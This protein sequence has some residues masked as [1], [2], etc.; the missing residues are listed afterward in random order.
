MPP[1]RLPAAAQRLLPAVTRRFMPGSRPAA[2]MNPLV[3]VD[4]GAASADRLLRDLHDLWESHRPGSAVWLPGPAWDRSL[5]AAEQA[6]LP[7][8]LEKRL[9][10]LSFLAIPA[11]DQLAC[12]SAARAVGRILEAALRAGV[13]CGISV[14]TLAPRQPVSPT[15]RTTVQARTTL[16]RRLASLLSGGLV[17]PLSPPH[18]AGTAVL[19]AAV[20]GPPRQ[21]PS[22]RR[23]ISATAR[24]FGLRPADLVGQSRRQGVTAARAIAMFLV[25]T[26]T[27]RSLHAIGDSF[28]GRD[29]TTVLHSVRLVGRRI[30]SDPA[31]AQDIERLL[32]VLNAAP[33]ARSCRLDV[34]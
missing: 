2:W 20:A 29:H 34:G 15:P 25:R 9:A 24:H 12:A 1:S 30:A 7:H 18:H 14:N 16:D 21:T 31:A 19:P 23:V 17:L 10:G 32:T 3:L 26:V 8:P 6:G 11:A 5:V 22:V 27:S 13:L 28:G 33:P 4:P